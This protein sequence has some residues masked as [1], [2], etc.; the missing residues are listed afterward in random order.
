MEAHTLISRF[1]WF[2]FAFEVCSLLN[3]PTAPKN[4]THHTAAV[5]KK[6]AKKTPP[7]LTTL[8]FSQSVN[9]PKATQLASPT[10]MPGG[11]HDNTTRRGRQSTE[12]DHT[13]IDGVQLCTGSSGG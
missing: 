7:S 8:K 3:K 1:F 6:A 13:I 12:E 11:K 5:D 10:V 9:A 2:F 4:G